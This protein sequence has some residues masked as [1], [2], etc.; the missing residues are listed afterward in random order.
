MRM[1]DNL[2]DGMPHEDARYQAQKHVW[3]TDLLKEATRDVDILGWLDEGSRDFHHALRVLKRS[4]GFTAAA[5]LTLA[6]GIGANTA[7]FSV[8]NAV[9]LHPLPYHH[10]DDL[11]MVW[12]SNSQ[13]P[14]P[15]NT[16][17][18]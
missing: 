9:L 13:H 15:H 3:N 6:L 11:V 7:I 16:V 2:W 4:P 17:S 12:E 5:V 18:P 10:P 14:N 8:I 1:A